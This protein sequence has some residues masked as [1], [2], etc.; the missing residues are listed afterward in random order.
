MVSDVA[1]PVCATQHA[2]VLDEA[3]VYLMAMMRMNGLIILRNHFLF[4]PGS[5]TR[6][7]PEEGS[8]CGDSLFKNGLKLVF[9]SKTV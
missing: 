4:V 5:A 2:Q 9:A 1:C 6:V 8:Q 7:N 3:I